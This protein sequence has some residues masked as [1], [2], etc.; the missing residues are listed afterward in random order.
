MRAAIDRLALDLEGRTVP[1]EAATG[2]YAVTPVLA[3]LAGA[4]V[5]ALGN[6][7]RHA[8][9]AD[10]RSATMGWRRLRASRIGCTSSTRRRQS[11]SVESTS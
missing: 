7:T 8:S 4:H 9:A 2:A 11:C 1:T 3:A 10:I 6:A 5:L